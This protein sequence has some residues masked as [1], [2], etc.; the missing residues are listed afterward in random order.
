VSGKRAT[1]PKEY[2]MKRRKKKLSREGG[3]V[4][5][6]ENQEQT[7]TVE[8]DEAMEE[9]EATMTDTDDRVY[10][11]QEETEAE[12]ANETAEW[13]E[14]SRGPMAAAGTAPAFKEL[15]DSHLEPDDDRA[16]PE[17]ARSFTEIVTEM[18]E[19]AHEDGQ[20]V[21]DVPEDSIAAP[22]VASRDLFVS[23]RSAKKAVLHLN[24]MV[25][26]TLETVGRGIGAFVVDGVFKGD[27]KVIL[28]GNLRKSRIFKQISDDE[29]LIIDPRRLGELT[30]AEAL[31]RQCIAEGIEV[32]NLKTFHF[33]TLYAVK[34]SQSRLRIAAE[35]NEKNWG[36]R[37]LRKAVTTEQN[38]EKPQGDVGRTI[39]NMIGSPLRAI[40]DPDLVTVCS[41]KDRLLRDL[42][43]TE[44]Q[45]IR[46]LIKEGKPGIENWNRLLERL[47]DALSE[48]EDN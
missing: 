26:D 29:D 17:D 24:Q 25:G 44:R 38:E 37:H 41:D 39:I 19:P 42:S 5:A 31:R 16:L 45:K 6:D 3:Q 46:T 36:V 30:I 22:P 34:D 14:N 27:Y 10:Q 40:E 7:G 43:A 11:E 13:H 15:A 32:G 20:A 9:E 48:L 8:E 33:V 4:S 35:A 47:D 12:E 18:A 1:A 21:A 2:R 23:V 28:S